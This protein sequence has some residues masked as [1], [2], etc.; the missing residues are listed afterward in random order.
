MATVRGAIAA[1]LN[2]GIGANSIPGLNKCYRAMPTFLDPSRWW[3]LP[4]DAGTGTLMYLH[5]ARTA[6]DRITEPAVQGVKA[7][8]YTVA[9]VMIS[10]YAVPTENTS[11]LEGD[12]WVDG[13]DATIEAVKAY[14]RADPNLG[15]ASNAPNPPGVIFGQFPNA[16]WQA[17]QSP[18]DLG[19][20]SDLPARDEGSGEVISFNVLEM[21]AT[22]V[23]TA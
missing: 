18:G 1:Y 7:V 19:M 10:R 9:L 3:M 21:H 22:E 5:L 11:A 13:L 20:T 2:Y 6:E 15:T 17:G 4:P 12:E 8:E 16:I 23:I 14:I